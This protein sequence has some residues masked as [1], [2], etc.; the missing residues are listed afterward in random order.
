MRGLKLLLFGA[1]ALLLSVKPAH[2]AQSYDNCVGFITSLPAVI[3]TQGTWCLKQDLTTAIT[4][5]DAISINTNNVTIDCNDFKLGGLAAGVGTSAVGVYALNRQNATLRRCNIRGFWLGLQFQGSGGGH[6]VENSRF[7]G[8]TFAGIVMNGDGSTIRDN[9]IYST[10]GSTYTGA[11]ISWTEAITSTGDSDIINNTIWGMTPMTTRN[12]TIAITV[13]DNS[14]GVVAGNRVRGLAGTSNVAIRLYGT[15]SH[16]RLTDNSL[17]ANFWA[18]T[19]DSSGG[20]V[21]KDNIFSGG[22][23]GADANCLDAGGNFTVP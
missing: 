13:G 4:S 20:G 3:T 2:A 8:N 6:L 9:F 21:L 19:C 16:V 18:V 1:F 12:D 10:G 15:A 17:D 7:D 11:L 5:G 22:G 23:S 14:N